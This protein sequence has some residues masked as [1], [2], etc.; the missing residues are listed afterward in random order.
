MRRI[1]YED[2]NVCIK[3]IMLMTK[4]NDGHYHQHFTSNTLMYKKMSSKSK[5]MSTF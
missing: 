2:A 4:S 1:W 5:L 3:R